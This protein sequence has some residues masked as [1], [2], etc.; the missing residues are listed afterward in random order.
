MPITYKISDSDRLINVLIIGR[1]EPPE[2]AAFFEELRQA[3][4]ESYAKLI[5]MRLA[6][7]DPSMARI[8]EMARSNVPSF[9]VNA[10]GP[11]AAVV[12]SDFGEFVLEEFKARAPFGDRLNFFR[13]IE[14]A[15]L[16]LEKEKVSP[17]T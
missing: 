5:D 10:R 15:R 14:Q 7:F 6:A 11:V 17:P 3:R 12:G 4:L 8:R 9:V 2:Y 13:D 16:W 1:V